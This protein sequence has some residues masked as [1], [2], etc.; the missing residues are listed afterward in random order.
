MTIPD[1]NLDGVFSIL[2]FDEDGTVDSVQVTVDIEHSYVGDL[3]IELI[4]EQRSVVLHDKTGENADNLNLSLRF[5]DFSGMSVR[6]N[7]TLRV[8]DTSALDEG[9]L[10]GWALE[11]TRR[12]SPN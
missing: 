10:Q 3:R 1:N 6:G 7:W 9:V 11:V 5:G 2:R 4:H 12:P 8:T